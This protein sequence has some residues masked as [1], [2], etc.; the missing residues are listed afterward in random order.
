MTPAIDLTN[1]LGIPHTLHEYRHDSKVD[2]YGMEAAEK[3]GI[4][5]AQVF[6]TLIVDAQNKG[7]AVAL[8]PVSG[9]LDLKQMAKLLG[10]K[11]VTM[12][13]QKRAERSSGYRL[14]GI[15][16]LGQKQ[17]LPTWIDE[18]AL[19]FATVFVSA[20]RRGLELELKP[21]HLLEATCAEVAALAKA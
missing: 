20:G 13:E 7:L 9:S 4:N 15:S 17:V 19:R 12:A 10:C 1:T 21:E 18:S 2:S 5:A 16:P 14:G 8:V 11:K 3:L 6:K